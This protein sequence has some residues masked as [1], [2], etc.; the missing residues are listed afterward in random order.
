MGASYQEQPAR[1]RAR[2]VQ[3]LGGLGLAVGVAAAASFAVAWLALAAPL[4]LG[5]GGGAWALGRRDV[6][7]MAAG[8]MHPAG[9]EGT[10]RGIDDGRRAVVLAVAGGLLGLAR[11]AA[12]LG[13]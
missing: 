11:W 13:L 3:V 10:R 7:A 8:R 9:L 1:H 4:A 2:L 6:R 5:L 12:L